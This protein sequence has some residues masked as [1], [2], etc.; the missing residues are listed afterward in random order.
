MLLGTRQ[1]GLAALRIADLARD[2]ALIPAAQELAHQLSRD[3]AVAELLIDRWLPRR[4]Q[5]GQ[6]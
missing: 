2:S 1:T 3:A 4:L 6:A 5:Y